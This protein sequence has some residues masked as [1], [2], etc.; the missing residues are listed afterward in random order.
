MKEVECANLSGKE[1][2]DA[3]KEAQ[4]L[5]R[6]SS[7]YV[8]R[9]FDSFMD[10][11]N[12]YIIMEFANKGTLD[13]LIKKQKNELKIPFEE[14][15]IWRYLLEITIGTYHIHCKRLIHRD[16]KTANIFL[17]GENSFIIMII[18]NVIIIFI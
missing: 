1:Q 17:C 9:Y 14:N 4:F 7:P 18:I 11:T 15:E 2:E 8:I 6:V 5:S 12:L 16:L 10:Q 13:G 3:V